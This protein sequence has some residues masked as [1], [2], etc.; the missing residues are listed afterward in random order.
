M[1]S[2]I[3]KTSTNQNKNLEY[4]PNISSGPIKEKKSYDGL[5]HVQC[6]KCQKYGHLAKNCKVDSLEQLVQLRKH[7]LLEDQKMI[8][9]EFE[10]DDP[11]VVQWANPGGVR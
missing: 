2:E 9:E 8:E 4:T 10:D 1:E 6:Y 7:Q 5:D 11:N 3:L